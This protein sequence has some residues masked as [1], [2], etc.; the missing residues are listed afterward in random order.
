MNKECK[1]IRECGV[2]YLLTINNN[3]PAGRPFGAI[4]ENDQYLYI[5][6]ADTKDVYHQL[7]Q[8]KKIQIIALKSGTR[9]WIR[10]TGIATECNDLKI[11]QKMLDECPALSNHYSSADAPHFN[12]FKIEIL[13]SE[14]N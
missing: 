5:S 6:T 12:I 14:F 2:F 7:K 9:N 13:N 11:K 8:N 3:F 4:I 1:F 10:I